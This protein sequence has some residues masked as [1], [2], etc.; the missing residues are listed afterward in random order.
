[1]ARATGGFV[2]L[3]SH[4]RARQHGCRMTQALTIHR[5]STDDAAPVERL[6]HWIGA[7]CEGFLEIDVTS[8]QPKAFT[9]ELSSAPLGALQLN[10]V[11]GSAQGV[12]RTRRRPDPWCVATTASLTFTD[13]RWQPMAMPLVG[14]GHTPALGTPTVQ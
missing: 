11:R 1:M 5:W 7:V 8:P 10:R 3:P 13:S 9:A 4:G 6:D 14:S 12:Y 2:R